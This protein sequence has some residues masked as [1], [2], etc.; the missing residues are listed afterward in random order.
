MQAAKLA[1]LDKSLAENPCELYLTAQELFGGGSIREICRMKQIATDD[2]PVTEQWLA[3]NIGG[4][5]R[6]HN[7]HIGVGASVKR[8]VVTEDFLYYGPRGELIGYHS[9]IALPVQ[10]NI[11][12]GGASGITAESDYQ[13]AVKLIEIP[14]L[15]LRVGTV[16]CWQVF[17]RQFWND[18]SAQSCNL[19]VHPVKF[20]P[21][22]WY[23]KGIDPAGKFTR[24]G[25]TQNKGSELPEDDTLGWIR[26]LKYESEFKQL[27]IAVTCNTW[28]GGEKYLALVGWVDEVTHR[29][30]LFH[31]PSIAT[32]E[33]VVV[34]EYDPGL[35]EIL[36]D[37]NDGYYGR[38]KD[39]FGAVSEKI[40][41]RKA[42]KIE[43][44]AQEGHAKAGLATIEI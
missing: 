21:R 4:L 13:R 5:A 26:K 16:F 42:L 3:E 25:F 38:F 41:M 32:T 36:M 2:F 1:W 22:A 40:M 39:V 27:P 28:D 29:T 31:L 15:G 24:T 20:A 10:D 6:K 11:A 17:F 35:Y 9:K 33:K 7:V 43:R 44:K 30:N 8:E 19:V 23:Q 12:L 34:T 37:W 18:L 14:A